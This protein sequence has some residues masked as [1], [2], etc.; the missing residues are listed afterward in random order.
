MCCGREPEE[1]KVFSCESLARIGEEVTVK[2][3]QTCS[4][5]VS[6]AAEPILITNYQS[7]GDGVILSAAIETLHQQYPGRYRTSVQTIAG[8]M[9]LHHPRVHPPML[10][11][12]PREL[13]IESH[14]KTCDRPL[15]VME[16]MTRRLG[17]LLGVPLELRVIRPYLYLSKEEIANR[18]IEASYW[19]IHTGYDDSPLQCWGHERF[20]KVVDMLKGKVQFVQV[21][22]GSRLS[23]VID[24]AGMT[25]RQLMTLVHHSRGGLGGTSFLQHLC[26]ALQRPF[27]AINGGWESVDR[28]QYPMQTWLAVHGALD[29]CRQSG[30]RRSEQS[31]CAHL[32]HEPAGA[33][34][35]CMAMIRPVDVAG[36]IANYW[37]NWQ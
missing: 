25:I 3:C 5:Y 10:A 7:P 24:K 22:A 1:H 16:I 8:E 15:H 6:S 17:E 33:V 21:G 37:D 29:C 19:L 18:P 32:E 31:E 35:R 26:A 9:W 14:V 2:D 36:V 4:H 11:E 20:Q 13:R 12:C 27:C 30:C 34:G 23:G 28:A